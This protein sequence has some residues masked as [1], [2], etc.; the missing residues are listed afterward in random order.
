MVPLVNL[1][2]SVVRFRS[3]VSGTGRAIYLKVSATTGSIRPVRGPSPGCDAR[4]IT[5]KEPFYSADFRRE[6]LYCMGAPER[7]PRH[8]VKL[9]VI[10]NMV[11][12]R[13]FDPLASWSRTRCLIYR[14]I[15]NQFRELEWQRI[16]GPGAK[17]RFLTTEFRP[18]ADSR[19][20]LQSGGP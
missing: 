15:K 1:K 14:K 20:D 10:E 3:P 8:D 17:T 16:P 6:T 19:L 5:A 13:G 11:G 9:Q 18:D 4:G 2:Q 12:E 7:V